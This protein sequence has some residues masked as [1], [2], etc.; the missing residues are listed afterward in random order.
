M[1]L[2]V[3]VNEK[4]IIVKKCPIWER[5]LERGLE[6]AFH[7][8]EI[9]WIPMLEGIGEKTGAKPE[10]VSALRLAH[11]EH[12]RIDYKKNKAKKAL[13]NGQMTKEE[14]DKEI[15]ML[16]KIQ[17]NTPTLGRYRFK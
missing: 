7:V 15:V 9:C 1:G 2:E 8:E 5:I 10:M 4:A 13:D 17:E 11:I 3:A 12:S 6:F 14:Y 16:D